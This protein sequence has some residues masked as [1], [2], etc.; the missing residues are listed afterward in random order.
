MAG[1][2]KEK[3][4]CPLIMNRKRAN[5]PMSMR[6]NGVPD[7]CSTY[8]QFMY[9]AGN[10]AV[11]EHQHIHVGPEKT[12]QRFLGCVDDGFVFVERGIE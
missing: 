3:L 6:K 4:S 10:H 7:A 9:S 5:N 2:H 12:F 8:L 1:N 11:F